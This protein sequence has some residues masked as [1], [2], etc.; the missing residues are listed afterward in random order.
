MDPKSGKPSPK[1]R[2]ILQG[3]LAAPVVLTVSSASAQMVT[4][5]MKCMANVRQPTASELPGLF[6]VTASI[7]DSSADTWLRDPISVTLFSKGQSEGWFY[8]D[9][10]YGWVNVDTLVKLSDLPNGWTAVPNTASQTR[11]A[12]VWVD[13]KTGQKIGVSLQQPMTSQFTTES[14]NTSVRPTA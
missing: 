5:H 1:R 9:A 3:S 6:F 11:W 12:L 8:N 7:K 4:S 13:A 2:A 10:A 14:C